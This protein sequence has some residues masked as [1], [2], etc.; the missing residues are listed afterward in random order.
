MTTRSCE[1]LRTGEKDAGGAWTPP[2]QDYAYELAGPLPTH[3]LKEIRDQASTLLESFSY[4]ANGNVSNWQHGTQR[5]LHWDAMG[6]LVT[7]DL[8]FSAS[9]VY[10]YAY[11][12]ARV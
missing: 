11:E 7:I 6:R 2:Y 8:S 5:H 10:N 3:R 12:E 9:Y 1:R 4:D